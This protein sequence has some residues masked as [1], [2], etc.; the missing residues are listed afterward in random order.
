MADQ[1]DDPDELPST[2][3]EFA[4]DYPEVWEAYADLGEA[5]SEAGPIDDETKRLVKLA[6]SIGAQSEGAVH[7]HVRRG[8]DED[9]DPEALKQVAAL[10]I[11]TLGFPQ[12]M[13]AISWIEDLTDEDEA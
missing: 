4:D 7:S 8:L 11:P 12:A 10:S 3:G 9:V 6:L 5:C 2:A 1:I 13:A